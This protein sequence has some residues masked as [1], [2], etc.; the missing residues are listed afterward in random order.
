MIS[1]NQDF[2]DLQSY[3]PTT[4]ITNYHWFHAVVIVSPV[5]E[6]SRSAKICIHHFFCQG[7]SSVLNWCPLYR[8]I[9][10]RK[11]SFQADI[12]VCFIKCL[13]CNSLLYK[14]F[15]MRNSTGNNM[16]SVCYMEVSPLWCVPLIEIPLYLLPCTTKF[17]TYRN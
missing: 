17:E 16:I 12:C 5:K 11:E 14:D 8:G 10:Q 3:P 7:N 2:R 4:I 15:T 6:A 1:Y 9:F 13:L